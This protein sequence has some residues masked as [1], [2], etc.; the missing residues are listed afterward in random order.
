MSGVITPERDELEKQ[1]TYFA[2]QVRLHDLRIK[3]IDAENNLE[4]VMTELQ[5]ME[6]KLTSMEL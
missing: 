3:K 4:K 6:A 1:K 2:H 5:E